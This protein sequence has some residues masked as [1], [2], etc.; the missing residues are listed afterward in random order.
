MSSPRMLW[1]ELTTKCQLGCGHCYNNSG[2]DGDHG[3][4]TPG[5]WRGVIVQAG[6]LGVRMVQFIGGEPTL[7]PDL[8]DLIQAARRADIEVEVYSNLVHVPDPLWAAL[9]QPGVRLATSF[10]SDDRGEHQ[11]VTGRDTHRQTCG[12]IA[13]ALEM[14]IPLRAGIV[15]VLDGQRVAQARTMLTK[16][17]VQQIGQDHARPFGRAA[18]GHD[19]QQTAGLCGRCGRGAAAV[20]PDGAVVPC[21][22]SRWLIAGNVRT[23][24]LAAAL[25]S[26][27]DL[28]AEVIP[29]SETACGPS[30]GCNPPCEPQCNPGC[31][32]SVELTGGVAWAAHGVQ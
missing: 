4:M 6:G 8:P 27:E 7:H 31:D 11:Q 18:A 22:M 15:E 16:M 32:P 29:G 3:V 30:D 14:G 23:E 26:V 17:G 24:P 25:I 1:L 2:V 12:N 19:D 13:R 9:V 28:A 10:Y 21:P 20:L 5:D